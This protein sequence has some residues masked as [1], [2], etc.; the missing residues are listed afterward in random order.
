MGVAGSDLLSGTGELTQVGSVFV[1][2]YKSLQKCE[3]FT[4]SMANSASAASADIT[5][6][7][8]TPV[9]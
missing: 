4:S 5:G 2:T 9:P 3:D 8:I 7:Y 1:N 6:E